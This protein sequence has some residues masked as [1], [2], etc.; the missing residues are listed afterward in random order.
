M[1]KLKET[2]IAVFGEAQF[3]LQWWHSNEPEL[4]VTSEPEDRK[5]SYAKEQLGVKP[6]KTKMLGLP[7]D[8]TKDTVAVTFP[9]APLEVTDR[10][11]S[12]FLASF[13]DPLGLVSPV[14]L[15]GKLLYREVC[16][17][18]LQWDQK[19][20][21]SITKQW[22]KFE[23]SLLNQV[24][25]P[26]SLPAFKETI[27]AVNLHAFGDTSGAGTAAAVYAVVHQASGINQGLL[28][29]KLHLAKQ[30]LT[31]ARLKLVSPHMAANLVENVKKA[32][33]DQPVRSVH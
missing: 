26:R 10:E 18:N 33:Q 23:K 28:E 14:S 7:W 24:Q 8:K 25:V 15:V 32:L 12:R 20:P 6:G 13:Y 22:K 9:K 1:R 3:K 21:E 16:G 27:E 5:Q 31:I 29:A 11:M 4:E 2:A 19:V 30:G 17:Q